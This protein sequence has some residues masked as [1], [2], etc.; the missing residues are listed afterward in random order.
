MRFLVLLFLFGTAFGQTSQS[1]LEESRNATRSFSKVKNQ[2]SN[3]DLNICVNQSGT[4]KCRVTLQGASPGAVTIGESGSTATHTINGNYN[5]G[6]GIKVYNGV[7][8]IIASVTTTPV[9][10]GLPN[11]T[12]MHQLIFELNSPGGDICIGQIYKNLDAGT[13]YRLSASDGSAAGACEFVSTSTTSVQVKFS[14]L[15][16]GA[17]LN[18]TFDNAGIG[19]IQIATTTGSFSNV[20]VRYI[21]Y[22]QI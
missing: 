9:T 17:D 20:K 4:E 16:T 2:T 3:A 7:S 5:L 6:T 18:I 11:V 8:S 12:G 21:I 10:I 19:N 15:G 13:A 14:D 1:S 22:S